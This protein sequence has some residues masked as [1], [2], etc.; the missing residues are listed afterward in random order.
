MAS[1]VTT[2]REFHVPTYQCPF[3]IQGLFSLINHARSAEVSEE[4][5]QGTFALAAH[6]FPVLPSIG[7]AGNAMGTGKMTSVTRGKG[8]KDVHHRLTRILS[9][10]G[11]GRTIYRPT[12][13]SS[14]LFRALCTENCSFRDL[15]RA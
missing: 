4:R 5:L 8:Q 7:R 11:V 15:A 2:A 12:M 14:Y 3:A 1:R 6:Q 13:R 10:T 9:M